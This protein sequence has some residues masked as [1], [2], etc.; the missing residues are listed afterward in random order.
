[1]RQQRHRPAD[2]IHIETVTHLDQAADHGNPD[3]QAAEP[4]I[5]QHMFDSRERRLRHASS[6]CSGAIL[7]FAV[8][9][10]HISG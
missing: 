1:M 3:L 7:L 6:P 8:L 5:L 10:Q 4:L 2:G 9:V